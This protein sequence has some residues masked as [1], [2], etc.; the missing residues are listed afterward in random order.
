MSV[1]VFLASCLTDLSGNIW[2][3]RL[4]N[5]VESHGNYVKSFKNF[6]T[7]IMLRAS[8]ILK[9]KKRMKKWKRNWK[10]ILVL[11]K[12]KMGIYQNDLVL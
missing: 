4:W 12:V 1:E 10:K 9:W 5:E 8:G 6:E 2:F 11:Y 7:E 3:L